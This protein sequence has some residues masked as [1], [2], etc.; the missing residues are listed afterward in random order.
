ML[1][2]YIFAWGGGGGGGGGVMFHQSKSYSQ[3]STAIQNESNVWHKYLNSHETGNKIN[4]KTLSIISLTLHLPS[5]AHKSGPHRRVD[6]STSLRSGNDSP[7]SSHNLG[8]GWVG[9]WIVGR[10][11]VG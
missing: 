9:G 5:Q 7:R 11:I 10:W 3:H 6:G 8:G 4:H 2:E 1:E